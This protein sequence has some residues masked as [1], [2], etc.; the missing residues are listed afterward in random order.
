METAETI[1]RSRNCVGAWVDTYTFQS[2]G[3]Y[4]RLGFS[5]LGT[6]KFHIGDNDYDDD[7]MG[8]SL[9]T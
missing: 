1:A 8:T 9:N 3:F 2:P 6:R 5:K 7:I 4:E